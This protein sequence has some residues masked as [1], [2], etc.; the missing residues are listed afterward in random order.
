T[1]GHVHHGRAVGLCLRV[2]LDWNA[3]ASPPRY[4][5]VA[6]ALGVPSEGRDLD[7]VASDLAPAYDRFIRSVGLPISLAKDGLGPSDASRLAS[8]T[9]TPENKPMRD[10]NIREVGPA[11]AARL[12]TDVLSAA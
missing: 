11:D 9:M 6:Q 10:A 5:A 3:Q 12:A 2:A 8:V 4:A 7:A 1:I